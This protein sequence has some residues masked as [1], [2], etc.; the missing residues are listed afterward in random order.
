MLED[1]NAVQDAQLVAYRPSGNFHES[2]APFFDGTIKKFSPSPFVGYQERRFIISRFKG[3][4]G[5]INF[6]IEYYDRDALKGTIYAQEVSSLGVCEAK[7][8]GKLFIKLKERT[9]I[10]LK[11]VD[12]AQL[13]KFRAAFRAAFKDNPVNVIEA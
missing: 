13:I 10:A 11:F 2:E 9:E 3:M 7:L 4:G 8:I 5:N 6:R 1:P 12:L